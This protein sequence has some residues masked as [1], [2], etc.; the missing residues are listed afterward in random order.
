MSLKRGERESHDYPDNN[1]NNDKT[2]NHSCVRFVYQKYLSPADRDEIA[3]GLSLSN[4][5]VF[6]IMIIIKLTLFKSKITSSNSL[7]IDY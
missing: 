1:N 7:I 3:Q 4:N 5:Q 2:N 6:I